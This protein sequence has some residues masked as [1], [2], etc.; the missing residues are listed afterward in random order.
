MKKLFHNESFKKY[1]LIG[2]IYYSGSGGGRRVLLPPAHP[3]AR[4]DSGK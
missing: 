4:T 1:I 2:I 3:R